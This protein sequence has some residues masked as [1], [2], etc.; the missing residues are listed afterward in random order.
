MHAIQDALNPIGVA[1]LQLNG[2][3]ANQV[4]MHYH[5]HLAPRM[6]DG[7]LLPMTSW[8]LKEGDMEAIQK[9]A[10]KIATAIK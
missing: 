9:T 1:A 6:A 5:L 4:V 10:E 3:G 2:K 8:E 7:P